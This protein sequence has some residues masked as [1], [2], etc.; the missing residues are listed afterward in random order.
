MAGFG[1]CVNCRDE[2]SRT[3]LLLAMSKI[4]F[5]SQIVNKDA[6]FVNGSSFANEETKGR[7][8]LQFLG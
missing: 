5:L 2:D 1:F 7:K 3:K 6:D 8:E 4:R